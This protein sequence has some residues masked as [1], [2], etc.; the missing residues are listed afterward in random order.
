ML[1]FPRVPLSARPTWCLLASLVACALSAC[2][3]G[4]A[5]SSASSGTVATGSTTLQMQV[6]VLPAQAGMQL[7]QP[8]FHAAPVLLDEPSDADVVD[9]DTS[10]RGAAHQQTISAA[11]A[12]LGTRQ[13]TAQAIRGEESSATA[14]AAAITPLA[15]GSVVS[16]YTPAQ[17]R[18][19]YVL[20][21]L[22]APGQ[23]LNATQAAQ[24]GAGQTIY[25]IDAQHDPNAALEL[26]AFNQK[27]ALP[28][29]TLRSVAVSASLP[30]AAPPASACDFLQVYSTAAGSM[31]GTAPS[32]DS[33]WATE[34][35]LD[36]QWAHATAPLARIVLIEAPD[37]T[38]NSLLGAVNLANAMGPGVVSMSFGGAEGNWTTSVDAAFSAANMS[39]VAATGDNGSGVS[40]PSVSS[41]VLAVGGTTL[42]Y[43]GSGTRSE[44]SWSGTGGGTSAY[45]ATPAYQNSAVPGLGTLSHRTVA[46]VAFNA[47][48]ASGQYIAVQAPGSSAASW[49][50]IGGTSLATPQWAGILAVSNALRA[51]NALS[52]LGAPHAALYGAIAS[53]PGTFAADFADV[54]SGSDGSCA[55]CRAHAGYDPLAGLGTPN[56]GSLLN[57]LGATLG[58][59]APVVTPAAI[60]GTVGSALSFT[61]A[62]T[63]PNALTYSLTGAPSGM[64]I[65][66]SGVVS[67]ASPVLGHYAVTVSAKDSKTAL[68]GQGLYSISIAAP[69]PPVVGSES[70]N[71]QPGVAL[72]FSVPYTSPD[73]VSFTLAGAP[74]GMTISPQGV[75]TWANP[76]LGSYSVTATVKDSKTGLSAQGVYSI[77][78]AKT[79]PSITAAPITGVAGKP[80]TGSIVL[81]DA[82]ANAL[83]V[84]ISGAPLGMAFSANGLTISAS[85]ASPQ[86]GNYALAVLA[87]DN[88]GQSTQATVPITITA[89]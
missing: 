68:T 78:I 4:G 8:F 5:D 84:T 61:V 6:P 23:A 45:V 51:Q 39:Y 10:A 82:G 67:W 7:A 14:R 2:G 52:R 75:V 83:S 46:D 33:G 3:G 31:T 24:L 85:W 41:H 57:S 12:A 21:A 40:W 66:S 1:S 26:A 60:S 70:I 79:G 11:A 59:S 27:F 13:L 65:S 19:A 58:N 76:V 53:T 64:A 38:L 73:S 42:T 49:M 32:Y 47:D 22:P 37:A 71:G 48:P 72:S 56:V 28:P 77:K 88:L 43:S 15:T 86:V 18:A 74:S 44:V 62:A 25:L 63:A 87:R 50:S 9:A 55:T 29:C 17:I 54:V 69:A 30:L 89:R 36:I 81:A 16:T 80:V 35:T 20:P 34:I